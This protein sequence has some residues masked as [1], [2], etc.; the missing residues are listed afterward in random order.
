MWSASLCLKQKLTAGVNTVLNALSHLPMK[1][2]FDAMVPKCCVNDHRTPV[3][4]G[5]QCATRDTALKIPWLCRLHHKEWE[6]A[7]PLCV[8]SVQ[9][10][11]VLGLSCPS[12]GRLPPEPAF[13][14]QRLKRLVRMESCELPWLGEGGRWALLS[15]A[16]GFLLH[17]GS[18]VELSLMS[19]LPRSFLGESLCGCAAKV[20]CLTSACL[21]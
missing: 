1:V 7:L 14:W 6:Q 19:Q 13:P 10:S 21:H 17:S 16:S 8:C 4:V 11:I 18:D 9:V 3:C 2:V 15:P 12:G 20:C 5:R